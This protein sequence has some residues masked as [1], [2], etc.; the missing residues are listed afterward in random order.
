MR[1]TGRKVKLIEEKF[2][3]IKDP[4]EALD[5]FAAILEEGRHGC[6]SK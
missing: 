4:Q 6:I 3:L 2:E 1:W 5:T